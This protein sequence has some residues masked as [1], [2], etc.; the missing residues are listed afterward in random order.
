M[1]QR[2]TVSTTVRSPFVVINYLFLL[3]RSNKTNGSVEFRRSTPIVLCWIRA[4]SGVR[5]ILPLI[6]LWIPCNLR[7][8]TW[9]WYYLDVLFRSSCIYNLFD[10]SFQ[11]RICNCFTHVY[12]NG[13]LGRSLHCISIINGITDKILTNLTLW[14]KKISICYIIVT[15]KE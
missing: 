8:K 14:Y 9:S 7:D 1:E 10:F 13:Q 11:E 3:L 15:K 5:S 4:E 6:S 2:F 12:L